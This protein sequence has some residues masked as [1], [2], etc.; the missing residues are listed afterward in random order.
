MH[1]VSEEPANEPTGA[2]VG[3]P[4]V[5][6][7]RR[8]RHTPP[9]RVWGEREQALLNAPP[10]EPGWRPWQLL[11]GPGTGKTALLSELAVRRIARSQAA[12][13]VLVL[14]HS[15]AA[16][17]SLRTDITDRLLSRGVGRAATREPMVRN[18]H[19]YAFSVLRLQ[20]AAC[21]NPPP[22]LLTGAEQDA[23]VREMLRGDVEDMRGGMAGYWPERLRPALEM[24]GFATE[25]GELLRQATQR[26]IGPE[27]LVK[28]GRRHSRP[29]WVAAGRFGLNYE[30]A[31][32]LRWSVS[33]EQ[34]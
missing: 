4:G 14:T 23:I 25:L 3:S 17:T 27:D 34:P 9:E 30:Q 10:S 32:L 6:L 5:R 26:G 33:L 1:G 31:T 24:G 16:A 21:G 13:S 8:T 22:R 2:G 20:A 15:R 7:V 28:L 18:V 19:S 12:D 11:G 29:E